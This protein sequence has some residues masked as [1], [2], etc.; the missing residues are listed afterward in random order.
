M[1]LTL[2][3]VLVVWTVASMALALLIARIVSV[4]ADDQPPREMASLRVPSPHSLRRI[5]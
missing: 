1:M 3:L 5:A 2:V 4:R